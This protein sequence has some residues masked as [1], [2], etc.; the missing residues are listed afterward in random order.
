V[1]DRKWSPAIVSRLLDAGPMGFAEL[2]A[3]LGRCGSAVLSES[4]ESLEADGVVDRRVVSERPYRVEY[5][6]T[7]KGRAFEPVVDA[8]VA[9]GRE[10]AE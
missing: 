8:M 7:G 10:Y 5:A 9:W 2:E 6:L 1:F 3:D 4:L